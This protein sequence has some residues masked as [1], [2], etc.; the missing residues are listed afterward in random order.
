MFCISNNSSSGMDYKHSDDFRP[1]HLL[2]WACSSCTLINSPDSTECNVCEG[3]VFLMTKIVETSPSQFAEM[4]R[5]CGFSKIKL[6]AIYCQALRTRLA[7]VKGVPNQIACT[8]I[9]LKKIMTEEEHVHFL[10]SV[11]RVMEVA[12]GDVAPMFVDAQDRATGAHVMTDFNTKLGEG[13]IH[14][15]TTAPN[16]VSVVF[17]V[18]DNATTK[19]W[20]GPKINPPGLTMQR[21]LDQSPKNSQRWYNA[22]A[23]AYLA[24]AEIKSA[25]N[26]GSVQHWTPAEDAWEPTIGLAFDAAT[27]T[28]HRPSST[29]GRK[30]LYCSF[31]R[32][33]GFLQGAEESKRQKAW[34]VLTAKP[35]QKF[36][37]R[38]LAPFYLF[39]T[40]RPLNLTGKFKQ[41]KFGGPELG[42]KMT[43]LLELGAFASSSSST[44]SSSSSSSSSPSSPSLSS[45]SSPSSSSSSSSASPAASLPNVIS[46]KIVYFV[47][48]CTFHQIFHELATCE[49]L[50]DLKRTLQ[51]SSQP[52]QSS[53][54]HGFVQCGHCKSLSSSPSSSPSSSSPP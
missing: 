34:D 17:N 30:I 8:T 25:I 7:T 5:S 21:L 49:I 50:N 27:Q 40:E 26:G 29:A 48:D 3:S 20:V 53:L 1:V 24:S 44:S 31:L 23:K 33:N 12:M 10:N 42:E 43:Y 46:E 22:E 41:R 9:H 52:S 14:V 18:D 35:S 11:A 15:D 45:L 13:A 38:E 16:V 51:R 39:T 4:W 36:E 28:H 19:I 2:K 6:S 37:E 54:L 47:P 32:K